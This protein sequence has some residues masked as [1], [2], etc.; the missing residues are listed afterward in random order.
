MND[1]DATHRREIGLESKNFSIRIKSLRSRLGLTQQ[2]LAD[3]VGVSELTVS[4]WENGQAMPRRLALEKIDRLALRGTEGLN[5]PVVRELQPAVAPRP[6]EQI[7]FAADPELVRLVAEAERLSYGH[8]FNPSFATEISLIDPLPHQRIAVYEHLLPQPHLRFLLADDAGA[9]KTIMTGLYLREMLARRLIRRVLIVPPAGL[10]GN[11]EREMRTLFRLPF[12]IATGADARAGNPFIGPESDLLI[13]SLDTL[14]GDRA[15]GFLGELGREGAEPYDAVIFD[16]AHKLS[17]DRDARGGLRQTDRYRLAQALAGV[18]AHERRWQLPWQPRHL[19][20]LTATPHMGKDY[21][22]YCLWRLLEPEGLPTIEAFQALSPEQRA[23]HFLRRTKEEMVFLDGRK[24]YPMRISDTLTFDLTQGEASEQQL[25]DETT[26]YLRSHYN[27][28]RVLNRSAARLAMGVFQRRLASST[29]ALLRSLE[30]RGERIIATIQDLEA[31]RLD[32]RDFLARQRRLDAELEDPF[33]D[34]TADEEAAEAG[35]EG[36]ER[37]EGEILTAVVAESVADLEAEREKVQDL[38]TLADRVAESEDSKFRRLAEV[39]EDP[40]HAGEKTLVFTEHRD[41]LDFL[42]RRLGGLGFAGRIAEIHGGMD[43]REREKQMEFFRRPG[44]EG[45]ADILVAT[46]AAGEGINLQFCWRM[47]N[48]DVPWNPA[49]LEQRMGRIH[50]YGQAHDPVIILNLVAAKT[51]EGRVL[52]TLL[53]KLERTRKELRSDKV[54]DVI[55]RVFEGMSL[56]RYMELALT[57]EGAREATKEIEGRLSPEQVRALEERE[58]LFYGKGG[59][60]AQALPRLRVA[61]DQDALRR[62]LPGYVRR[63]VEKAAPRLGLAIEGSLEADF[64]LRP[65]REGALDPLLAELEDVG[66]DARSLSVVRPAKG[67]S[68]LFFHP[69]EAA[70]ERF[71]ARVVEEFSREASRGGVFLDAAAEAPYLFH[72]FR[73]EV[74]RQAD[75]DHHSLARRELLETR[76]VGLRETA[77]GAMEECP[78]E[79]LLLLKSS[80]AR[81]AAARPFVATARSRAERAERYAVGAVAQ[82]R[83]EALRKEL[84]A[85]LGEREAFLRRGYDHETA[86]LAA[87]RIEL[88]QRAREGDAQAKAELE[89]VR[90]RQKLIAAERDASLGALRREPELIAPGPAVAFVRALILPATSPEEREAHDAEVE[91]VAMQ[92]AAEYERSHGARVQDVSRPPL[93]RAAGLTDS[94]GFDLLSLRPDGSRRCIEVKGRARTGAVEVKENEWA[95]ACNLR[96]EYWLYAVFGCATPEPTLLRVPDPFSTLLVKAHGGVVIAAGEIRAVAEGS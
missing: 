32:L 25:Y 26:S 57:D 50:R 23:R 85:D 79:H 65:A 28:A 47:V 24:I 34:R 92:L 16:E 15:F 27:R 87:R 3:L 76:L 58:R 2:A 29:Y 1:P 55:G 10:I 49:R 5:E 41:T 60:V 19:L 59:E 18:R 93:A 51:R 54:F 40:E 86:Q 88:A 66:G 67:S 56:K 74:V 94:P 61:M 12:R 33:D 91:Q 53:D 45:G 21:P 63:F 71:R 77:D 13:M 31:G 81:P 46:D 73:L 11:W 62:I 68:A 95:A 22:Y 14:T 39:L 83:A 30:R 72:L 44:S 8:L 7:D 75:P 69:G 78:V 43:F 64:R 89:R 80:M 17:A 52:H 4:R 70:F 48:Y 36:H 38:I 42:V 20:L 37:S 35:A 82:T 9:G 84:L 6:P 96:R 90:E